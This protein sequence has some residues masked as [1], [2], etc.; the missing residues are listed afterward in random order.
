MHQQLEQAAEK[1]RCVTC[2]TCLALPLLVLSRPAAVVVVVVV[3]VVVVLVRRC[4]ASLVQL[5]QP[6]AW[7]GSSA[8]QMI[9]LGCEQE[10]QQGED[11]G[12]RRG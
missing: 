10:D 7:P 5:T 6:A 4:V 3:D 12:R 11:S 1:H 9:W 2:Q 8:P